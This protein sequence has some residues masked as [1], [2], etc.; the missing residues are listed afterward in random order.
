MHQ[1]QFFKTTREHGGSLSVGKRRSRR[2]LST[3]QPIHITLRSDIA[4]GTRSLLK[5]KRLI[6][7]TCKKAANLFEIKIYKM[8]ICGNH[9][10]LLIRGKTR[11]DL[12]NFFRVLSGHV[13]QQILE[14][15]PLSA[16]EANKTRFQRCCRKNKRKFW[17]LLTYSR[18]ISW[19]REFKVVSKY[20]VQNTLEAL[21]LIPYQPRKGRVH[22]MALNSS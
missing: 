15:V 6:E 3:K 8:A 4:Y 19:G 21:G 11:E 17:S 5:H 18:I 10:H 12:Q 20:I 1:R 2:S 13:A 14:K 16:T 22:L 9:L 7:E